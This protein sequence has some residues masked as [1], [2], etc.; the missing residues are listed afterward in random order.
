MKY[1]RN[2][3]TGYDH[4]PSL[5]CKRTPLLILTHQRSQTHQRSSIHNLNF[6]LKIKID[7]HKTQ[8]EKALKVTERLLRWCLER[9][10]LSHLDKWSAQTNKCYILSWVPASKVTISLYCPLNYGMCLYQELSRLRTIELKENRKRK[11]HC[12]V[13]FSQKWSLHL[14]ILLANIGT[15]LTATGREEQ[16]LH[17]KSKRFI[18]L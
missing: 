10:I 1:H 17:R 4:Q 15:S 6:M 11:V 8:K 16:L 3:R 2:E 13:V 18:R 9:H 14:L 12:D 5:H 7:Y